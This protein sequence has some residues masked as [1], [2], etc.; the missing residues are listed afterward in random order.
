M[1]VEASSNRGNSIIRNH[2]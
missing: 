1:C 2:F